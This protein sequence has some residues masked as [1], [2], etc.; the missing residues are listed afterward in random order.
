MRVRLFVVLSASAGALAFAL[1]AGCTTF[2]GGAADPDAGPAPDAPADTRAACSA[3]AAPATVPAACAD[4]TAQRLFEAS[5]VDHAVVAGTT[6]Y[7]MRQKSL[8]VSTDIENGTFQKVTTAGIQGSPIRMA[9]DDA[10]VYVSTTEQHVR[11]EKGGGGLPEALPLVGPDAG[12]VH[13]GAE[14]FYRLQPML[15]TRTPKDGGVKAG[16]SLPVQNAERLA[17]DG[18]RA[19][20]IGLTSANERII[21]GP[22]PELTKHGVIAAPVLGFAVDNAFAYVA[23]D[24][25]DVSGRSTIARFSLASGERTALLTEPGTIES[26]SVHEGRL[27]W[28]AARPQ[29]EGGRVFASSDLCGGGPRVHAKGLEEISALSF[30]AT[31]V[32]AAGAKTGPVFRLKK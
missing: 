15:V 13:F 20:W 19:Y 31:S 24:D 5:P 26:L 14:S 7:V 9:V 29:T 2:G 17:L 32:Y 6:I 22:F 1:G 27:Y 28:I 8:Q 4:C 21:L 30:T 12:S 10:Y 23:E 11:V 25:G 16:T 18:D 3:P